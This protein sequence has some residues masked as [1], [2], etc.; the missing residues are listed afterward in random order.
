MDTLSL[1]ILAVSLWFVTGFWGSARYMASQVRSL[2]YIS[3]ECYDT[4]FRCFWFF[5]WCG[6]VNL[7]VTEW[8][9]LRGEIQDKGLMI[10]GKRAREE[11]KK[12]QQNARHELHL[13]IERLNAEG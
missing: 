2:K 8:M 7:L 3:F 11:A 6:P 12:L 4:Q 13:E 9:I 1:V 5:V 10:P